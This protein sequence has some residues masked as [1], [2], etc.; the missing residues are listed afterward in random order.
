MS[1]NV[2][3]SDDAIDVEV[4]GWFDKAMCLTSG[5]RV[6]M[7][8]VVGARLVSWDEAR[9][10][11]GWRTGGAYWPGLIATGWYSIRDR[12]GVRQWWC[13][14]R[15]RDQLLLVDT[16]LERPCR[17]VI[18]HDDRAR[19]AWWINERVAPRADG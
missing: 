11:L 10:D 3:V 12:P 5:F 8:D 18:A 19:L 14:H 17:L 6:P 1:V 9:A 13:V 7:A 2:T 4:T 16:R 15:D